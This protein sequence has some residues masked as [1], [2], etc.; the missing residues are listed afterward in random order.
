MARRPSSVNGAINE[1]EI[2][3]SPERVSNALGQDDL[4][5]G[6][7]MAETMDRLG[8]DATVEQSGEAFRVSQYDVW[9]PTPA[10]GGS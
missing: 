2:A 9:T 5:V 8:F 3:W 6:M 1:R 7:T 4:Y 10:R